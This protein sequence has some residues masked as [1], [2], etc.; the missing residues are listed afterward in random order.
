MNI[1][2]GFILLIQ[3]FTRIPVPVKL[4]Y[5]DRLYSRH[6]F[7]IPLVGLI[8]GLPLCGIYYA[9][10]VN[11]DN[12]FL[13]AVLIVMAEIFL[14][15]ALHIDGLAD[16]ADGFYSYRDRERMLE[17][18]KDSR[19]GTNGTLAIFMVLLLR[20]ALIFSLPPERSAVM[21]LLMPVF[22]RLTI[23]WLAGVSSYARKEGMG[24]ALV[25]ST[26]AV[27][28]VLATVVT[29]VISY[30]IWYVTGFNLLHI[31]ILILVIAFF[32]ITLSRYSTMKI[33][34]ITGDV[35]GA[36]IE[37]SEIFYLS[38]VLV[39]SQMPEEFFTL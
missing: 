29:G 28:I 39:L 9:L 16:S 10:A 17:I 3:F 23:P 18:M 27:Q 19:I 7:L 33:G 12:R 5:D 31:P 36:G 34:G 4:K 37:L 15:G 35:V 20:V 38:A 13:A 22:S 1:I 26:G 6:I 32:A 24:G 21:I 2:K 11:G 30:G 8:L 25:N 14:T